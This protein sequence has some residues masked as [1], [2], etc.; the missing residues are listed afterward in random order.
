MWSLNVAAR[1][2]GFKPYV[3]CDFRGAKRGL[4]QICMTRVENLAQR[5]DRGSKSP[6]FCHSERSEEAIVMSSI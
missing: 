1:V 4:R 3:I 5:K 2:L 6:T